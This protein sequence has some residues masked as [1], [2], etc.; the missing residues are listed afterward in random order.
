MIADH[1][2]L[3]LIFVMSK[4]LLTHSNQLASNKHSGGKSHLAGGTD[5]NL[6]TKGRKI[7]VPDHNA[8]IKLEWMDNT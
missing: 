3:Y 2:S 7:K 8:F 4:F 1:F 6:S 5:N